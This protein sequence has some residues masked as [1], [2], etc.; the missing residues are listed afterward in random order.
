MI[1][2][3]HLL[4]KTLVKQLKIG[5]DGSGNTSSSTSVSMRCL[6]GETTSGS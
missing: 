6:L 3:I 5:G 4:I 2:L 1:I